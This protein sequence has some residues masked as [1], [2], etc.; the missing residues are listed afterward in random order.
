M[1]THEKLNYEQTERSGGN[2]LLIMRLPALHKEIYVR[3]MKGAYFRAVKS[4]A[5]S[6]EESA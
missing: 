5:S 6:N 3:M 2:T 1:Q 4:T